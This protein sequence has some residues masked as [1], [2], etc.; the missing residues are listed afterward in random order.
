MSEAT[1]DLINKKEI[2]ARIKRLRKESGLR[3]W[4]LAEMIRATQ[5]AIHMYERGVLP[6]PKRLLELAR[7][8][9]TTVE[10]ILT[11][12]H[13]E[14]GSEEM[15]RVPEEICRLAFRLKD[16]TDADREALESAL[17]VVT[18]AAAAV[19]RADDDD[20]DSPP[21]DELARRHGHSGEAVTGLHAALRIL[22]AVSSTLVSQAT[23]RL[24]HGGDLAKDAHPAG[25]PSEPSSLGRG[26]KNTF[27]TR[28]AGIEP[29]RGHIYKIDG[30]LLVISEIIKDKELRAEFEDTLARLSDKLETKKSKIVKM[31]RAQRSK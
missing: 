2:G 5:P 23:G 15:R 26:R 24:V 4:Q 7:I 27:R 29:I 19:N 6:E 14:N 28:A 18:A 31:K 13:W 1:G 22:A 16:Y 20:P 8:G 12:R 3:Q 21:L 30:S 9:D 25:E 10:W 11:G 17:E